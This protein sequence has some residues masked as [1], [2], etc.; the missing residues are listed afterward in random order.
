MI[1]IVLVLN[2]VIIVLH[3]FV[4][5]SGLLFANTSW[6]SLLCFQPLSLLKNIFLQSS[7]HME[8]NFCSESVTVCLD[9]KLEIL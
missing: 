3:L 8:M 6:I 7:S 9:L 2:H 4:F 1:I 5:E